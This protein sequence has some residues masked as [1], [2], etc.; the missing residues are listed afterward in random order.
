MTADLGGSWFYQASTPSAPCP[1]IKA[2]SP[3][4]RAGGTLWSQNSV[5][6][7]FLP[8]G[9]LPFLLLRQKPMKGM[10]L[11]GAQSILQ[12]QG[13]RWEFQNFQALGLREALAP[14]K[15]SQQSVRCCVP[16]GLLGDPKRLAV[17]PVALR[18]D[19]CGL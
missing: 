18:L 4:P 1:S 5:P 7:P 13:W 17:G 19:L 12:G 2:V 3:A 11:A 9:G 6:L 14:S 8:S 15:P 10:P 16:P